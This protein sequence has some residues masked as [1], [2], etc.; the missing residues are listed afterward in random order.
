LEEAIRIT[1]EFEGEH[2]P[3]LPTLQHN[4]A[5]NWVELGRY[6]EAEAAYRRSSKD[7]SERFGSRD[8]V[9]EGQTHKVLG[10]LFARQARWSDALANYRKANVFFA[11]A[12]KKSRGGGREY[13]GRNWLRN[14]S[15]EHVHA[16][17]NVAEADATQRSALA[18]EGFEIAQWVMRTGAS[19]A[20][21]QLGARHAAT[22]PDLSA[23]IR[24][25]QDNLR[26]SQQLDAQLSKLLAEPIEKRDDT[27]VANLRKEISEL[28]SAI[29]PLNAL[30]S[31]EFPAYAELSNPM[32]ITA[33]QVR[34]LLRA[35]E[36]L[37]QYLVLNGYTLVWVVTAS[38]VEWYRVALTWQELW[39]K[40]EALRC[41][42]DH[43][44]W[45]GE[46]RA[47]RCQELLKAVPSD[48]FHL[49][50]NLELAHSLYM[51]LLQPA[52]H[53]IKAKQLLIAASNVLTGLPFHLLVTQKPEAA[54]A[55]SD[56]DY[57]GIAW[58]AR[59]TPTTMVPSVSSLRVQREVQRSR[60]AAREY[61][62]IGD[63]ILSEGG[64]CPDTKV[65][66][67][68]PTQHMAVAALD[69]GKIVQR[70]GAGSDALRSVFRNGSAIPSAVRSLCRLPDT[71][72]ELGCVA[73][74]LGVPESEIIL[75][76]SATEKTLKDLNAKGAL[77]DYRI[78][79]FATHGLL[80]G[81]L[82][83]LVKNQAEPALV[84]TPPRDDGSAAALAEDDGLL[85]ASEIASLKLNADW[86]ILSACNTAGGEK[87]NAESLSGLAR[88]F[89]YAG[90][91]ALLV[92]HWEVYT[93]AAVKLTTHAFGEMRRDPALGRA[94]A[95]RRSMVALIDKGDFSA[96][97]SYWA[98]FIV[99][100]DG[101]R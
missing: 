54:Y 52:E 21:A 15:F 49:P 91:R 26:R 94:E 74:S 84:L 70:S 58:L 25:R 66:Q 37:V 55:G 88:A 51:H 97:P 81:E 27:R 69:L 60:S 28:D 96:H 32:P 36:V 72:Y 80:A 100:G 30:L 99:V 101:G 61:L 48:A 2:S 95:L 77:A 63:P 10:D 47:H 67:A 7:W 5:L 39:D 76:I 92:S 24:E 68:C 19:A 8:T 79:H 13:F 83:Q 90:A 43:T 59:N 98:P 93:D 78:L 16:L 35:D 73:K 17:W 41:G 18:A 45:K 40:V 86:V 38:G 1:T 23:K 64:E 31:K 6:D 3:R 89:F 65:P 53:L 12:V 50:F 71:A 42:F 20:L 44:T 11:E 29:G 22:S 46:T 4:L 82:E 62:G 34:K 75:G 57:K 87:G 33:D 14:T 56:N 9:G 85:T